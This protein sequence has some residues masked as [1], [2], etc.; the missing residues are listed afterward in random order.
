MIAR[1]VIVDQPM[2]ILI[3]WLLISI[4]RRQRMVDE[5]IVLTKRKRILN[6]RSL[7]LG[8]RPYTMN[9]LL[10]IMIESNRILDWD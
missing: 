1:L 9:Q 7:L 2:L 10:P 4:G 8:K 6:E 5:V 3:N